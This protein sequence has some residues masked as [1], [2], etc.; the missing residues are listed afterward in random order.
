MLTC[1][2]FIDLPGLKPKLTVILHGFRHA[3]LDSCAW[4]G[5]VA[6]RK[7]KHREASLSRADGV[8]DPEKV[9]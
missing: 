6:A 3:I 7:N 4:P 2:T 1:D 9:L 5:G 8:V